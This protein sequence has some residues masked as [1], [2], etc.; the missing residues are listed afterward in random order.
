MQTR[1]TTNACKSSANLILHA[2]PPGIS[3][4]RVLSEKHL[5][6]LQER[7]KGPPQEM[8]GALLP[9]PAI[10]KLRLLQ[11]SKFLAVQTLPMTPEN[12]KLERESAVMDEETGEVKYTYKKQMTLRWRKRTL[13]S[14]EEVTESNARW[15]S[16]QNFTT[17]LPP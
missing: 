9:V 16:L 8:S 1:I 2:V 17:S 15:T 6:Q 10:N 7:P 5:V 12:L 4:A 11:T 14:G 13:P 3:G